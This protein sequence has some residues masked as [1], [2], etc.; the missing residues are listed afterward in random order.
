MTQLFET[1]TRQVWDRFKTGL[2][3]VQQILTIWLL[4][5]W[6][7]GPL[8]LFVV[9]INNDSIDSRF[10]NL[11]HPFLQCLILQNQ[12]D[13]GGMAYP[14]TQADL[15]PLESFWLTMTSLTESLNTSK[16]TP[17]Y[18]NDQKEREIIQCYLN[19]FQFLIFF[20][21]N[22]VKYV[23]SWIENKKKQVNKIS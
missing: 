19:S 3:L 2:R 13:C 20:T 11:C 21:K 9:G 16:H 14:D 4:S 17:L 22:C 23:L 15:S 1:K 7:W 18:E 10:N 6:T 8:L 5:S 12:S